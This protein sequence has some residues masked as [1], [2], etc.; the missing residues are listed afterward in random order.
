MKV[1][2]A[3]RPV[4][5]N[6]DDRL[7]IAIVDARRVLWLEN[8]SWEE[9]IIHA[10]PDA[11]HDNVCFAPHDIN[12]DGRIDFAL[13]SDWQFNNTVSGGSIG[14]LEHVP[15]GPWTYHPISTEPTTHRMHWV[16]M[17]GT[18]S[19]G[20]IVAPLKGRGT[21]PPGFDQ[22][23]VRL[24]EFDPPSN[25]ANHASWPS[26]VITDRLHVMHNFEPVDLDGDGRQELLTASYEGVHWIRWDGEAVHLRRLG[27]GQ[28]TP[29]P[30]RGA[31]EIRHGRLADGR[32]F[33]ATIEPWHGDKV[34]VYLAPENWM[35]STELW[36]R[37][38]LDD[39][40]AWGH[41]V[42]CA[43]LDDDAD[44]ELIIG[45]RDDRSAEHRRG[46][47]IYDPIDPAAGKWHRILVDPGAVA[48]EDLAVADFDA[49]GDAD[50][51]AVGRQTHN[52]RIYWNQRNP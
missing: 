12:G 14:W 37:Y 21:R 18:G 31:S 34:V 19:P 15:E 16:D 22:T 30:Q 11:P 49:D 46:L 17:R 8:P 2:Y 41:A 29:P 7:D 44:H 23:G 32:L 5:V 27:S 9:R 42:A 52:A 4:D 38:V 3:V 48:I 10:T 36:P 45:V 20:L 26:R 6:A 28:T 1:G 50:I 33:L 24:L 40:L 47:R 25:P 39:Q 35:D 51:V 13:G 43:N